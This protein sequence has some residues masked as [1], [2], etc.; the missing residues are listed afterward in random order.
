MSGDFLVILFAAAF[1]VYIA[2]PWLKR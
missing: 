1:L 2:G